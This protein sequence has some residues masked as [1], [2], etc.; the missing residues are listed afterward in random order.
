MKVD[1]NLSNEQ[2]FSKTKE[3]LN[4]SSNTSKNNVYT[5]TDI[6]IALEFIGSDGEPTKEA[7]QNAVNKL[8][9]FMDYTNRNSKF[10]FHEELD[11]YYVE[12]VDSETNEVVKEIPPKQLL[13]AFYE[14]RKL[15][16]KIFDQQA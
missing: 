1:T 5:D 7:Y 10:V 4:L 6:A 3:M 9:E 11:K 8:N 2:Y 14:M 15:A 13:D 16:G 12:I